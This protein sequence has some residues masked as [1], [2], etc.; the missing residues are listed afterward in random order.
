MLKKPLRLTAVL[1]A[2]GL[3]AAFVTSPVIAQEAPAAPAPAEAPAPDAVLGTVNGKPIT[4]RDIDFA[5]ADLADQLG[6]VPPDQQRFAALMAL[7][8]IRLLA[9]KGEADGIAE[10][11]PFVQRLAFLRDRALHNEIFRTTVAEA[12]TDE[13]IRARYDTEVAATPPENE[14]SARHILLETEEAAKAVIEELK[15]GADFAALA[16]A[17]SKDPS[18]ASNGG[19][20]GYFTRGRMVPEFETAAFALK[21]GETTEAP[22]QSQFGW[23]VIRVEDVRPVQPPAFEQVAGQVRSLIMRERYFEILQGLRTSG[24]VDI[25]DPAMKPAYDAAIAGQK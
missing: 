9:A 4:N 18:G 22:V 7:I 2:A 14:I 5:L 3:M 11:E 10:K 25:T 19:D 1:A 17:Q 20:L 21:P 15:G 6:Q 8:D 12:I 23:H 16:T 13:E 24:N